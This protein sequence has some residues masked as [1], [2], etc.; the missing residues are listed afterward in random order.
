MTAI[1][2]TFHAKRFIDATLGK[3]RVATQQSVDYDTLSS[4][5]CRMK[6]LPYKGLTK[7]P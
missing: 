6:L 2:I 5:Q 4:R 1:V 3:A 7:R